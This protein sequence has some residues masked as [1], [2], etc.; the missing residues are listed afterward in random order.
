MIYDRNPLTG[1]YLCHFPHTGQ[2]YYMRTQREAIS[3]CRRV[4]RD[5][6]RGFLILVDGKLLLASSRCEITS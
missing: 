2:A 5:I 4:N 3:F 6:A 1:D